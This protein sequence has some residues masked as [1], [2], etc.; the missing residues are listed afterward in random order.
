MNIGWLSVSRQALRRHG[1]YRPL[2]AAVALAFA[3][4]V[5]STAFGQRVAQHAH[6]MSMLPEE[7]RLQ[8]T[9]S[10][11]ST[12]ADLAALRA[13]PGVTTA[14]WFEAS[15]RTLWDRPELFDGPRGRFVGWAVAAG[16]NAFETLGLRLVAGR[17]P[18]R[19]DAAAAVVPVIVSRSFLAELG[20]A[21]APGMRIHSVER[22]VDAEIAGVVEDF[23]SHGHM[24]TSH[25]T[26][27]WPMQPPA[28]ALS[29]YLVRTEEPATDALVE[30][31]RAA[32][33]QPGRYVSIERTE[34]MLAAANK[35]MFGARDVLSVL[36]IVVVGTLLIGLAAAAAFRTLERRREL[37]VQRALGATRLD[38]VATVL[39]ESTAVTAM[40]LLAGL[41]IISILRGPLAKAIPFF[42]IR[43]AMVAGQA[44]LFF[45]TGWLASLVPALRAARVPPAAAGR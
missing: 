38:I 23:M 16:E 37:A 22:A 45:A 10:G 34:Q 44:L 21:A 24:K 33:L 31:A 39:A 41:V 13:L 4:A 2:V 26:V 40:G 42:T 32:L 18:T 9:V 29:M 35:P 19:E 15:L 1:G 30:Q 25:N 27:L 6:E 17:A 12:A 11:G 28:R 20:P 43:G 7:A 3:V 5:L 14:S 8:I 36:E